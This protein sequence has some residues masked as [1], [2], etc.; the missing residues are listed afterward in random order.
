MRKFSKIAFVLVAAFLLPCFM[1]VGCDKNTDSQMTPNHVYALGMVTG[2]EFFKGKSTSTLNASLSQN[3]KENLIKYVNMFENLLTDG[4]VSPVITS[5]SDEDGEYK[6]YSNKMSVTVGE[7]DYTMYYTEKVKGSTTEIDGNDKE[8]TTNTFL[9]GKIVYGESVFNVLGGREFESENDDSKVKVVLVIS[10][11]NLVKPTNEDIDYINLRGFK[12]YIK[13]E[14]EIEGD[15]I[16]YVYTTKDSNGVTSTTLE[17]ENENGKEKLEVF[18]K[19]NGEVKQFEITKETNSK[20]KVQTEE[21]EGLTT[22]YMEKIDEV[23]TFTN[24]NGETI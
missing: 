2:T 4:G 1:F 10:S 12:S 6:A 22:F 23:W 18:V 15:E 11:E 14:Q 8:V 19:E 9:E 16:K 17:W 24:Q 21:G 5:T 3:T 20:F 13:I 7:Q